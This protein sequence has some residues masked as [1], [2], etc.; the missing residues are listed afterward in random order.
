MALT[1]LSMLVT[2]SN[3][4]ELNQI[5]GKALRH[6]Q[7]HQA[8]RTKEEIFLVYLRNKSKK[9]LCH[10]IIVTNLHFTTVAECV[11]EYVGVVEQL[12][13]M[14]VGEQIWN[15]EERHIRHILPHEKYNYESSYADIAIVTVS[16][17]ARNSFLNSYSEYFLL[18]IKFY[19]SSQNQFLY[20]YLF[21]LI[22]NICQEML[23][24]L[25]CQL[26]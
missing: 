3:W 9:D 1:F 16:I 22:L 25:I 15:I 21:R 13:A 2:E 19:F 8:R 4:S 12:R 11:Y 14:I 7:I 24:S 18:K 17:S 26:I 23:F 20:N 10:G 5:S 6:Q